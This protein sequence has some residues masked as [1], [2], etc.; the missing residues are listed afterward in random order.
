MVGKFKDVVEVWSLI[1]FEFEL[2][3]ATYISGRKERELQ[4]LILNRMIHKLDGAKFI[5]KGGGRK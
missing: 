4:Y 5:E 3:I 1:Y 2:T